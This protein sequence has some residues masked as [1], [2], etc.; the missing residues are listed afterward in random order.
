MKYVKMMM[1]VIG[2]L[3]LGLGVYGCSDD[4]DPTTPAFPLDLRGTYS[5]AGTSTPVSGDCSAMNPPSGGT[6]TFDQSS[7]DSFTVTA[8]EFDTGVPCDPSTFVGKIEGQQVT[9]QN[10]VVFPDGAGIHMSVTGIVTDTSSFTLLG[11]GTREPGACVA[12][13]T[14]TLTKI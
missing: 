12:D 3:L 9:I 1:I 4:D 5:G 8:C 10:D 7:S 13:F 14:V 6:V 11:Q 2:I